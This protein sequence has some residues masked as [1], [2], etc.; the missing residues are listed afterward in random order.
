M[1]ARLGSRF[2]LL[3]MALDCERW[4]A[5]C[6]ECRARK[7]VQDHRA[8]F[9]GVVP[10]AVQPGNFVGMDLVSPA[11]N[12]YLLSMHCHF[13]RF[14]AAVPLKDASAHTLI[15]GFYYGSIL[16]YGLPLAIL[17]DRG[18]NFTSKL[19]KVLAVTG[20][21]QTSAYHPECNNQEERPH[22]M[23]NVVL[24]YFPNLV[25]LNERTSKVYQRAR[26]SNYTLM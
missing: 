4:V 26:R 14:P 17:R 16:E 9:P 12:T 20:N 3:G 13:S 11:G 7:S 23:M 5:A 2:Y 6:M 10:Q 1:L 25:C 24:R 19:L 8:G 22:R 15:D 21:L 18:S